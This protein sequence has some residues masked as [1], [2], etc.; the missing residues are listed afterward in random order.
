ME[1]WRLE[2]IAAQLSKDLNIPEAQF[3]QF[4]RE[5]YM[6]PDTYLIPRDATASAVVDMLLENFNKK[7]TAAMQEDAKKNRVNLRPNHHTGVTCWAGRT[8][9]SDRPVIAAY[10]L[11]G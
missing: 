5:G 3:I 4:A 8:S 6:F 11:T 7:I 10:F 9:D 2:E 1:G